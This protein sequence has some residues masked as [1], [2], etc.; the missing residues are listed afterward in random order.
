VKNTTEGL[1]LPDS[2]IVRDIITYKQLTKQHYIMT[3]LPITRKQL[4]K[5][6]PEAYALNNRTSIAK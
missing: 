3:P 1:L 6:I 4:G 2:P 5:Y